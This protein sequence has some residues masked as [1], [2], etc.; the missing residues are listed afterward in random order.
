MLLT[1]DAE[2]EM[3]VEKYANGFRTELL[4]KSYWISPQLLVDVHRGY[5]SQTTVKDHLFSLGGTILSLCSMQE[6]PF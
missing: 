6:V 3:P 4:G 5:L 1:E 2:V